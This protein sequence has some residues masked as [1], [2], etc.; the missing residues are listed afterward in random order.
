MGLGGGKTMMHEGW[1]GQALPLFFYFIFS[2]HLVSSFPFLLNFFY[3]FLTE[4][5]G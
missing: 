5:K 4:N 3:L 2:S 1:Q